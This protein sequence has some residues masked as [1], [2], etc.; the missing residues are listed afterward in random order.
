MRVW[1]EIFKQK[2]KF[3]TQYH[4]TMP[5]VVRCFKK[6]HVKR[7]LDLGCG[8]GRHVVYLA[9]RGFEVY[10]LDESQTGLTLAKKWL[11]KEK[12][13]A[14]LKRGD[15]Y[16]PYPYQDGFFDA[17]ISTQAMHHGTTIK[18]KKAI[19]E[20]K[21]VLKER[22]IIF[23]TVPKK[24]SRLFL[25]ANGLSKFKKIEENVFVP[26]EG[27]EKGLPHLVFTKKLIKTLFGDFTIRN[28]S[29]I[30]LHYCFMGV[31]KITQ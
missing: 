12:I 11:K 26:L 31:K 9:A 1:E 24:Q 2:G 8:T 7:V 4:Q 15:L 22:G 28:I 6:H 18:V 21:R 25:D 14:R 5:Q 3:F 17:V 23:I 16:H 13:N 30:D 29:L 27:P 20:I 10:G 19:G